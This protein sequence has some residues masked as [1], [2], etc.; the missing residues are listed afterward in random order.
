MKYTNI[1]LQNNGILYSYIKNNYDNLL[2]NQE[3]IKCN[4]YSHYNSLGFTHLHKL[5]LKTENDNI[6][7]NYLREY[8]DSEEGK[9]ELNKQNEMGITPLIMACY[10]KN[11]RTVKL[12]LDHNAI[13]DLQDKMGNNALMITCNNIIGYKNIVIAKMLLINSNINLQNNN[14]QTVLMIAINELT[15]SFFKMTMIELLLPKSDLNIQD[16]EG[17]TALI[18]ACKSNIPNNIKTVKCLLKYKQD[19]FLQDKKGLTALTYASMT[20]VY[21]KKVKLIKKY[22]LS[23]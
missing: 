10:N 4:Y 21:N 7:Y 6:L 23:F 11:I 14:G 20:Q 17:R 2:I 16:N 5:V 15:D 19:L 9:K 18:H 8:L 12:L 13:V 1:I 3:N 22:E